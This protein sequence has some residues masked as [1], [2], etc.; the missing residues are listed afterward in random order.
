MTDIDPGRTF[1]TPSDSPLVPTLPFRFRDV[2]IL[3][4]AYR[5]DLEAVR[6]VLPLPLEPLDDRVIVHIY[7][8]NDTD[9]FGAYNESA[10]QVSARYPATG[11]TG[12]YSP[13]LYLD[14]DGGI[15]AGREIYGQ[16]KKFGRPSIEVRQ[17]L[18]V[19]TVSRNGIDIIT[20]TMP[21]KSGAS[22]LAAM[23]EDLGFVTNFNLKVVPSVTGVDA[24]R[25]L[26]ARDLQDLVVHECWSGPGTVEL[27]PNSQAPVYRLPVRE[28]L[29]GY[30]WRCDFTL[31][32][33]RVVHDYLAPAHAGET[34]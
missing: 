5:T 27:R 12:A 16:P 23:T 4:V 15:A 29:T 26:T 7:Q 17:D 13:Y 2:A 25:Q 1:S 31:G 20:A 3:T 30:F 34:S 24:I 6:R 33:G 22:S 8:M 10:V 9:W 11:E 28:M 32:Y 21:Y 19:G 18:L 14:H